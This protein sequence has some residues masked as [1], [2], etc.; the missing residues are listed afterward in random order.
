MITLLHYQF[1]YTIGDNVI[2]LSAAITLSVIIT[3]SVVTSVFAVSV[4]FL[5]VFSVVYQSQ[6]LC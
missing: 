3:L 1:Y 4:G 5:S 6:F 2:T